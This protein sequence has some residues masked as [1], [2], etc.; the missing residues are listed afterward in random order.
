MLDSRLPRI[1]ITTR[2]RLVGL[3]VVL[4]L[5]ALLN[6]G[7]LVFLK[8]GI[9]RHE[10]KHAAVQ[11][12]A[13][14]ERS[15]AE[16]MLAG[17]GA[18]SGADL[19]ELSRAMEAALDQL[20]G[21]DGAR[22][23]RVAAL[24]TSWASLTA[25]AN[26]LAA[27]PPNG[28]DLVPRLAEIDRQAATIAGEAQALRAEGRLDRVAAMLLPGAVAINVV[29]LL[30]GLV[31]VNDVR[32]RVV[33]PIARITELARALAR[34]DVN[35]RFGEA[36]PDGQFGQ[37]ARALDELAVAVER[38]R[39]LEVE[40]ATDALTDLTNRRAF[41]AQLELAIGRAEV[42]DEDFMV[43]YLDVNGFKRI[44]DSFGHGVGDQALIDVATIMHA[45]FRASDVVARLGGDEFAAIAFGVTAADA[46]ELHNRLDGNVE[47]FN[48]FAD[49]PYQLS[50]SAGIVEY[51][52]SMTVD[53]LLQLADEAM[54]REKRGEPAS[55]EAA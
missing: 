34:G 6:L 30:L 33:R 41:F 15:A 46:A 8:G 28:L 22:R 11:V 40:V 36:Y 47:E 31:L 32:R 51:T 3:F 4:A 19:G 49:R 29:A 38:R 18:G 44:N 53:A 50:L 37:L 39:Q 42:G 25:D 12:A 14:S 27:A 23:E 16:V 35:Q 2:W 24:R 45:T 1:V 7:L 21:L 20:D 10:A 5:C 9:R 48:A 26:R 54:Y 52:S 43:C 13:L 17:V 55:D